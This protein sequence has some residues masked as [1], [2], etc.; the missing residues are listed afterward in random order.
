M[1]LGPGCV[2]G[3]GFVPFPCQKV[4]VPTHGDRNVDS[5]PNVTFLSTNFRD[6]LA[7]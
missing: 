7:H 1:G 2:S 3:A 5:G 4:A 6:K